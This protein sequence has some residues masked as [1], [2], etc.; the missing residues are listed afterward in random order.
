M[1]KA[2]DRALVDAMPTTPPTK[3]VTFASMWET[4]NAN[5][6]N[7]AL[8]TRVA[9]TMAGDATVGKKLALLM[10]SW[11]SIPYVIGMIHRIH[12]DGYDPLTKLGMSLEDGRRFHE[13]CNEIRTR[14]A[15]QAITTGQ[16]QERT[17]ITKQIYDSIVANHF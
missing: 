12:V 4:Y 1:K 13:L 15:D 5:G 3:V 7:T 16:G 17:T 6:R 14:V 10:G 9:T 8:A 2:L 11:D